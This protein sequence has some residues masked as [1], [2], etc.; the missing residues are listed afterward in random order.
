MIEGAA[1][2]CDCQPD[3]T[4]DGAVN[5]ADLGIVLS[6]WGIA[7]SL[8]T[9]DVSRDGVVDGEDLALVLSNWGACGSS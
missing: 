2:V 9:G 3:I 7:D 8:G 6:S 5:G 1:E 4:G